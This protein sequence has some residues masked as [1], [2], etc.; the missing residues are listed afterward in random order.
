MSQFQGSE[1]KYKD[2]K[3]A[4]I[5]KFDP[6]TDSFIHWYKLFCTTGLQWGI[7]CPPYE[8]TKADHIHG[9]WWTSLPTSVRAKGV[10][11]VQSHLCDALTRKSLSCHFERIWCRPWMSSQCRIP[12]NLFPPSSPSSPTLFRPFNCKRYS[13]STSK[14][15][16]Q[17][18]H[19]PTSGFHSS[20]TSG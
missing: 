3:K 13:A 15:K 20:R 8:S 4:K 10:V 17:F 6:K 12:C 14:R 2:F 7:W 11:Y 18:V 19:S 16:L 1:I 9:S 5:A